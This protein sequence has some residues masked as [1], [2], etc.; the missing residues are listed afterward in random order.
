MTYTTAE[1]NEMIRKAREEAYA[2]GVMAERMRVVQ[3]RNT[4]FAGAKDAQA[5]LFHFDVVL[6][7]GKAAPEEAAR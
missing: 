4:C 3:W 2:E 7:S 5:A 1:V 6:A